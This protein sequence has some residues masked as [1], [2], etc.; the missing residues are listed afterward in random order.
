MEETIG[1][2]I[3]QNRKRLGLTQ[4]AL[5]EKLGVTAQAVSKWEN[6]QSCPD[7][8]TLPRLAQIFGISTDALLGHTAQTL[9]E[10]QVVD[11]GESRESEGIH[12]NKGSWSF[13]WDNSRRGTFAFALWVL[14]TGG[15]LLAGKLLHWQA[16]LWDLL[17]PSALLVFGGSTLFH[18]FSFFSL[19]CT[20]FGGYFLADNL[21]IMPIRLGWELVLPILLVLFGL[22]LLMDALKKPKHAKF[23]ISREGVAFQDG[24]KTRSQFSTDEEGFSCDMAFGSNTHYV[25]LPRLRHGRMECSFGELTV[26]LS[27]CEEVDEECLLYA[28]CSFGQLNILVPRKFRVEQNASTAFGNINILGQPDSA[29]AGTVSLHADASFGEI[30]VRYI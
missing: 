13:K 16:G 9:H 5:A 17:W 23:H 20:L 21:G 25:D 30:Q 27:G 6:D 15:L 28:A 10:A 24:S 29:P 8:T 14:L 18:K 26:D 4:D 7:I 1:K 12:L 19:G 3:A 2:R 11:D 22:S